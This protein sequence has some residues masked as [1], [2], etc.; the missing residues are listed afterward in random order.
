VQVLGHEARLEMDGLLSDAEIL[1][2]ILARL[3]DLARLLSQR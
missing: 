2:G 3:A 1:R